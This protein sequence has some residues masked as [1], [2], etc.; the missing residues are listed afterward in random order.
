MTKTW[1]N[2]AFKLYL[3]S[4]VRCHPRSKKISEG[5]SA[6]NADASAEQKGI[7]SLGI[8]KCN[9]GLKTRKEV[10]FSH[11]STGSDV[12]LKTDISGSGG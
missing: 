11:A 9:L 4:W 8:S 1:L 6:A 2:D 5:D 12:D 3:L 10:I 7:R